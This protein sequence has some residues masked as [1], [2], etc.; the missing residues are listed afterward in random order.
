MVYDTIRK[1]IELMLQNATVDDFGIYELLDNS[2]KKRSNHL[3]N[4][5]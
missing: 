2:T 5:E 1:Q 3:Y 4:W